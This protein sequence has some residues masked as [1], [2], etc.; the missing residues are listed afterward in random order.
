MNIKKYYAGNKSSIAGFTLIEVLIATLILSLVIY[1]GTL[2]YSMFL[3]VWGKKRLEDT[4][5]MRQYRY[6]VMLKAALESIYDYYVTDHRNERAGFY[7]PFFKGEREKIEFVTLSSAFKEGGPALA[8]L[9]V[10]EQEEGRSLVYE[11]MPLDA[12]YIKYNDFQPGYKYS[13]IAYSDVE[14]IA[15]RYY[16][17]VERR[18]RAHR[19]EFEILYDWTES[20]QGKSMKGIPKKI[21]IVIQGEDGAKKLLFSVKA[22]NIFKKGFFQSE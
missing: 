6:H 1:A 17:E 12:T 8:R 3:D 4:H 10:S 19:E 14:K 7:Y 15:I 21:E 5:A 9:R 13:F 2:S 20:F 18:M 16:G 11:E 22:N